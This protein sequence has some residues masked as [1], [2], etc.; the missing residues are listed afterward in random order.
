MIIRTTWD[1]KFVFTDNLRDEFES[2]R[3][4]IEIKT[5]VSTNSIIFRKNDD[6]S[7]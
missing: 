1:R 5:R 3:Q 6:V 4:I 7:S 2:D